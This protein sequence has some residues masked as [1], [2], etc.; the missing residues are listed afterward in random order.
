MNP[1]IEVRNTHAE[2]VSRITPADLGV[3]QSMVKN[4]PDYR[5][6]LCCHASIQS[7]GPSGG[8]DIA[9]PG[10]RSSRQASAIEPS[11]VK[12]A[13]DYL[14]SDESVRSEREGTALAVVADGGPDAGLRRYHRPVDLPVL[15]AV[16]GEHAEG[17]HHQR[18]RE[19]RAQILQRV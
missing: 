3:L 17:Q 6:Q 13:I 16:P 19:R 8:L 7:N 18:L 2:P 15:A 9:V 5:H 4:L 12:L 10:A 1:G 11:S 14:T